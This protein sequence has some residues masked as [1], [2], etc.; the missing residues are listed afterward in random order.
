MSRSRGPRRPSLRRWLEVVAMTA[1]SDRR[2]TVIKKLI[3]IAVALVAAL[4]PAVAAGERVNS[5]IVLD[6]VGVID[7]AGNVEYFFGGALTAQGLKFECMEDRKVDVFRDEPDGPDRRIGS[8]RTDFLGGF[9]AARIRNLDRV[10][11]SYYA[12]AKDK[13]IRKAHG[14]GKLRCLHDRSR[15]ITVQ[16]PTFG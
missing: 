5:H 14:N 1:G 2:R 6:A 16:L 15:P 8:G 13:V 9:I 3:P 11:G 4:L 10:P 7:R 12:E